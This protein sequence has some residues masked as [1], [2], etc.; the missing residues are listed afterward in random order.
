MLSVVDLF[1]EFPSVDITLAAL[2]ELLPKQKPRLYSISSCPLLHPQLL[3]ITVGVLQIKTD[4][5]KV[6]QGFC[7][8][9]LAGLEPG[10]T[11]HLN[12]ST[13]AFRPPSDPDA[14]MLM[15]GP[16]TGVS[17]LIA[18]LQHREALLQQGQPLSDACLY[19][20]C[21]NHNDFLYQEQL[22]VWLDRGV[23]SGL[24]V[25]FSRLGDQKL[26]VQNLMQQP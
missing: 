13:P 14:V 12:V 25:A 2:L 18:F 11:V 22:Q 8:N 20:G 4:A 6:R 9:Y 19:F 15:V 5:G 1:D 17:P 23:L 3:Q 10:A 24:E 26:Y 21:R 16:G 7:S